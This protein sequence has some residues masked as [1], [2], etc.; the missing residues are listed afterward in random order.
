MRRDGEH[1]L[2]ECP[3][4]GH[5]FAVR[6]SDPFLPVTPSMDA[7]AREERAKPKGSGKLR[8]FLVGR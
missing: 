8:K 5:S 6:L 4:C 2:I 3:E 7:A 1:W